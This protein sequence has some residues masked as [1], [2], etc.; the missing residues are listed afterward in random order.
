MRRLASGGV[1]HVSGQGSAPLL[2]LHGVGGAAWSWQPQVE[3]LAAD[4]RCYAW[5]ARGHGA[6]QRVRDAGLEEYFIDAQEA[7][8]EVLA[9]GA[10]AP[11]VAG[12]SMGG[13]LAM[14]LAAERPAD[15]RGLFLI[16]PVY[17]PDGGRH[18]SGALA[19]VA[20]FVLAPL[21]YDFERGGFVT[22]FLSRAIFT[23][24]FEDRDR[25]ERAW[26]L[27]RMQVPTEYPK[28]LYEAFEGPTGFPNRAFARELT[29]PVEL[30]EGSVAKDRPR[31]PELVGELG[32]RLG[33]RFSYAAIEG[34]HYLQLDRSAERVS[35]LL[36]D[37]VRRWSQ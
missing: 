26:T 34:G 36:G 25:M 4:C 37:F 8:D 30:V 6:A 28:M 10:A 24:A 23:Q 27:Q 2:L 9:Q 21:V 7:L 3:A 5:E 35:E 31:F 11:F 14:A 15:V 1:L 17:A 22:R 33:E 16:E 19:R 18:A 13:L 20:R 12:H 32:A 29:Q